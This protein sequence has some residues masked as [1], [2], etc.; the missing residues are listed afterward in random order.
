MTRNAVYYHTG[1]TLHIAT[2]DIFNTHLSNIATPFLNGSPK[3]DIILRDYNRQKE[4]LENELK[5][6]TKNGNKDSEEERNTLSRDISN[7][8]IRWPSEFIINSVAHASKFGT[9]SKL[10]YHN[11]E[12]F[13]NIE[14]TSILD[15][16]SSKLFISGIGVYQPEEFSSIQMDLFLRNKDRFKFIF[17][18][19]SIV[20]GTNISLS[21]IDIDKSFAKNASKNTLYQLAGRAGRSG[22]SNSAT[23]F[24]RDWKMI[25]MIMKRDTVNIEAL[26]IENNYA[27]LLK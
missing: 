24:F 3:L 10:K 6:I 9:L 25:E 15:D 22:K 20:Y 11:C 17:S 14:E 7:V 13:G 8:Q 23:I 16:I 19:P 21:I 18:T 1:K 4:G 27:L 5:N 2:S 26:Q 12:I